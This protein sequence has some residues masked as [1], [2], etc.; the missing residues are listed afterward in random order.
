MCPAPSRWCTAI[1]INIEMVTVIIIEVIIT[2]ACFEEQKWDH[3]TLLV[4]EL[5]WLP[6]KF[7]KCK[8]TTFVQC[9]FNGTLLSYILALPC[10]YQTNTIHPLILRRKDFEFF[11]IWSH[12]V[13]AV[14]VSSLH[15][16]GIHGLTV[17]KI[18]PLCLNSNQLKSFLFR[19][20]FLQP[21]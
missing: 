6:V 13:S 11:K 14:S 5:H 7:C 4:N 17:W 16:P 20:A 12:L 19:P 15:L 10:I 8:V 18:S 3:I 1:V 2:M 21:R 9:H